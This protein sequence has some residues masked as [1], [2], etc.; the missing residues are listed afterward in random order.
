MAVLSSGLSLSLSQDIKKACLRG[1]SIT[2]WLTEVF[3]LGFLTGNSGVIKIIKMMNVG[4][5]VGVWVNDRQHFVS[6][7][8]LEILEI[9]S[10][11]LV[12]L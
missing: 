11:Y 3:K 7:A 12:G 2:R 4:G 1:G 8:S 9:L 5:R 6:G 10:W